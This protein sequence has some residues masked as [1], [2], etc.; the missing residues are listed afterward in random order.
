[1]QVLIVEDDAALGHFLSKC[2]TLDGH[3]VA[4][5]VDGDGALESAAR[6]APDLVVLDLGLPGKDGIDVL[7]EMRQRFR[8]TSVIVL[9]GRAGMEER[10]RCLELGADDVV[11]KPFS[12]HELRARLNAISRRRSESQ[13]EGPLLRFGDIAMDRAARTV[14]Q[15]GRDL[16]LTATE[17]LLLEALLRRRGERVCTRAELLHEVWRVDAQTGPTGKDGTGTNIV[18]VYINYLRKK[19]AAHSARAAGPLRPSCVSSVC[20]SA[21]R[22]V[23]G[24]GYLLCAP[25]GQARRAAS[26]ASDTG[27]P[28]APSRSPANPERRADV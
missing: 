15:A 14:T 20:R 7:A 17:F 22:T 11:L 2:L 1:M 24:Q 28:A 23:R 19:L 6:V 26:G 12:F 10:V 8:S 16:D 13:S 18:E 27:G 25:A 21:I 5:E 3:D 4:L 9:T